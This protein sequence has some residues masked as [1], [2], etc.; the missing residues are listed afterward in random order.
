MRVPRQRHENLKV[1]SFP[2]EGL[3]SRAEQK[4]EVMEVMKSSKPHWRKL[5]AATHVNVLS[6][7]IFNVTDADALHLVGRQYV[8]VRKWQ[9]QQHSVGVLDS[10]TQRLSFRSRLGRSVRFLQAQACEYLQTT[11]TSEE[12]GNNVTEVGAVRSSPSAGKPRT[13]QRDSGVEANES[14][15]GFH[16]TPRMA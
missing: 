9:V 15:P 4:C 12:C 10:G 8:V 6:P 3:A 14:A 5:W 11:R 1:K 2:A 7:V 16:I 13:W